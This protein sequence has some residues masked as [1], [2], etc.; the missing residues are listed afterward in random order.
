V[1]GLVGERL[2]RLRDVEPLRMH[3]ALVVVT[4]TFAWTALVMTPV[5]C[6]SGMAP[7]DA[8]LESVS[9][10]TTTASAPSASRSDPR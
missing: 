4:G 3:E 2:R 9:A 8:L 7:A 1:L 6:V 5:F 10:I